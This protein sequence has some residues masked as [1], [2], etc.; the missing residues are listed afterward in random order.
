MVSYSRR[1]R[2]LYKYTKVNEL[3][4]RISSNVLSK[5]IEINKN[6]Y[7]KLIHPYPESFHS[8]LSPKMEVQSCSSSSSVGS[9]HSLFLLL[10][11]TLNTNQC[12]LAAKDVWPKDYFPVRQDSN[13]YDFIVVGAGSAGSVVASRLSENKKWKV[14]L[15]EAGG[16][17]PIESSVRNCLSFAALVSFHNVI[18]LIFLD[19]SPCE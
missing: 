12:T 19:P 4:K 6:W 11:Q 3:Y 15:I 14:L 7:K 2:E 5:R 16:D 18:F 1:R 17:P 8:K 9:A 13:E 10:L